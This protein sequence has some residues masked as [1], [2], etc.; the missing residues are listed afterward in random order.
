MAIKIPAW[1]PAPVIKSVDMYKEVIQGCK[2]R[3]QM[4]QVL[5]S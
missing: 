3:P 2:V 1:I 5:I 4:H